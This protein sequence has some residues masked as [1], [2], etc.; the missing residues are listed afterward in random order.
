MST[1][2]SL[3]LQVLERVH[4]SGRGDFSASLAVLDG[5][6]ALYLGKDNGRFLANYDVKKSQSMERDFVVVSDPAVA[7]AW[8]AVLAEAGF[9]ESERALFKAG[10]DGMMEKA[11]Y[12]LAMGEGMARSLVV[13]K[14]KNHVFVVLTDDDLACGLTW[15]AAMTVAQGRFDNV[16]VLCLSAGLPRVKPVKEKWEAFGWKIFLVPDGHDRGAL[17]L[18][19]ARA[20][21]FKRSPT[22]VV[23]PVVLGKGVPF[24]EGKLAYRGALLSAEEWEVARASLAGR[25][26][27]VVSI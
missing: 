20:K 8:H 24:V 26:A 2:L 3:R 25:R 19:L 18:A 22:C 5:L 12:G 14:R 1:D 4:A 17:T 13:D 16:T 7:P 9:L 15:E 23:A 21:E 6:M 10:V 11:G 27:N